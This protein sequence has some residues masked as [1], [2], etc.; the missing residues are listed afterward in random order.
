MNVA[1]NE[2][3]HQAEGMLTYC[4]TFEINT[5]SARHDL[6]TLAIDVLAAMAFKKSYDFR[7]SSNIQDD[8]SSYRNTLQTALDNAILIMLI[9]Y[10]YLKGPLILD[11]LVKIGDAA[12]SGGMMSSFIRAPN[13]HARETA[14]S[15][16][17]RASKNGKKGLSFDEILNNILILNFAGYDTITNALG[18]ALYLLAIHLLYIPKCK[19]G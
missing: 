17:I 12:R 3:L 14:T 11:K 4:D 2:L 13:I 18:F 19:T 16:E 10:R 9:P 1:W 15:P 5:P 7:G 6:K 8:N